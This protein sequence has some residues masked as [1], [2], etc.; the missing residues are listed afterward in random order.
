MR[1][2]RPGRDRRDRLLEENEIGRAGTAAAAAS[3]R[4]TDVKE[5]YFYRDAIPS[6]S[7]LRYLY[8]YPQ[9]AF[10]YER[11]VEE[12]GRRSR[13]DPPFNLLDAGAF[14]ENR[15]FDVEAF[16]AKAGADEIHIRIDA[17][18]RGPEDAELH[19]LPTLWF[20]NTWSWSGDSAKPSMRATVPAYGCAWAVEA[21]HPDLG[22]YWLYGR[23][24]GELLF[25]E[26]E[27]NY[28]RL[29]EQPNST[30]YVKDAFH[31]RVIDGAV[32][33][34]NLARV[35]TK[36]AIWTQLLLASGERAQIELVLAARPMASPFERSE[37]VFADRETEADEFYRELLHLADG[38]DQNIMRQALAGM[39]WS[40]QF[41]HYDVERSL[42]GDRHPPPETRLRGRNPTWRHMKAADVISM[43][44]AWEF[45]LVRRLGPRITLLRA[46]AD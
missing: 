27:T 4:A 17:S 36:F 24:C 23:R 8:K 22:N 29:W 42:K 28:E 21:T 30:P 43:P 33:A 16:Y 19:V 35:G 11:L 12:N 41:F 3:L 45:S 39:I 44:D 2:L 40:K 9:C 38:D 1:A 31:R 13:H 46:R 25:T 6:H 32:D 10:P 26:N 37:A 15:Y 14:N 7:W 20:R 18:N 34:V 5:Y